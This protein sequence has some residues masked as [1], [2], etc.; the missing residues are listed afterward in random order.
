[1]A[2]PCGDER[3]YAFANFLKDKG[4]P[5]IKNISDK[6]ISEAAFDLKMVQLVDSDF[7]NGLGG[8]NHK[9][10]EALEKIKQGKGKKQI[11]V[12]VM[13]FSRHVIGESSQC[14]M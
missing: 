2:V 11:T 8:R 1:M 12:C 9:A 6:D 13:L 14:I 3:D 4:M 5:A 7:L 10:I